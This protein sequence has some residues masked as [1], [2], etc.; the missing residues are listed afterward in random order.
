MINYTDFSKQIFILF[1]RRDI[2]NI[3]LTN[4]QLKTIENLKGETYDHRLLLGGYSIDSL[5]I[6]YF[7]NIV[8]TPIIND[9][10]YTLVYKNP[11]NQTIDELLIRPN[12][13]IIFDKAW[14]NDSVLNLTAKND[15][16]QFNL[17]LKINIESND[18]TANKIWIIGLVIALL[19]VAVILIFIVK[20]Y[21]KKDEDELDDNEE[22][23]LDDE[24]ENY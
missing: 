23:L 17:T 22:D 21:G 19:V 15:Y 6:D 9:T 4:I 8:E 20:K 14:S 1:D 7:A 16:N 10:I 18:E 13:S 11:V 12:I 3:S 24:D 2:N 5:S